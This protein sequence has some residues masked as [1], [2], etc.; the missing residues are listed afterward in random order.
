MC[1]DWR[2]RDVYACGPESLLAFAVEHWAEAGLTE[3]L[4]VERFAPPAL[5]VSP[6]ATTGGAS[7]ATARFVR[8][9]VD[10]RAEDATP[11]LDVAERAGIT[12]PS[13]CRRGICH[14]CSTRLDAGR[15]RDLRDGRLL[16]AGAHV[17]LCVSAAAGDVTLDL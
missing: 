6:T 2:D 15:V 11:L 7:T 16:E 10:V 14:T 5:V 9:G 3:R 12:A 17:Q 1:A 4:H 8:S 13:G